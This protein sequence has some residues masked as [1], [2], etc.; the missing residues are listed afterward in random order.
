[1]EFWKDRRIRIVVSAPVHVS[2]C[3]LY[4]TIYSWLLG[5]RAVGPRCCCCCWEDSPHYCHPHMAPTASSPA[6]TEHGLQ[7]S[8]I[9]APPPLG[10]SLPKVLHR[11]SAAQ[12]VSAIRTALRLHG[13]VRRARGRTEAATS[14]HVAARTRAT[15]ARWAGSTAAWCAPR[16]LLTPTKTCPRRG[17]ATVLSL[18]C[19]CCSGTRPQSSVQLSLVG[20]ICS[21][22]PSPRRSCD[23]P[24]LSFNVDWYVCTP[25]AA[26]GLS[27]CEGEW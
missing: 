24:L 13:T 9:K 18:L 1:M 11:R 10:C 3:G 20:H 25:L 16:H 2:M 5:L 23:P 12:C 17:C 21:R 22:V 26:A 15:G 8:T 6:A 19:P 27:R 14:R 4:C 7:T